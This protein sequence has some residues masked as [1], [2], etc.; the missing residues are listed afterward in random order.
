MPKRAGKGTFSG[1]RFPLATAYVDPP[2]RNRWLLAGIVLAAVVATLL[3][4]DFFWGRSALLSSG[5]VAS[6]HAGLE[7]YCGNCHTRFSVGDSG[8]DPAK[9]A[10]CHEPAASTVGVHTFDA[11]YVYRSG[12]PGRAYRRDGETA[13]AACHPEHRGRAATIT[14]V[15]DARCVACHEFDSFNDGHPQFS[16]LAANGSDQGTLSFGH[17]RHVKEIRDR[18]R[19]DD[20]EQTC[21]RCHTPS[22][23]GRGF[24]PI[25]FERICIT[26]H[27]GAGVRSANLRTRAPGAPI[28]V[29]EQAGVRIDAGVETLESIR[30]RG[31]LG[32][33]W[34]ATMDPAE[35]RVSG[36]RVMK[37]PVQHRDPWITHNLRQI[38][39]AI[40]PSSEL[41]DLLAASAQVPDSEVHVLYEEAI[42][43]LR[44]QAAELRGRPE[45]W[46]QEELAALEHLLAGVER[47][48]AD[49]DIALDPSRFSLVGRRDPR[50]SD[51]Q[52]DELL[53]LA[54]R[55]SAP[56]QQ[57][58]RIT[59]ASVARVQ[60]EQRE[61]RRAEFDHAVHALQRRCLDCHA[62]IPVLDYLQAAEPPPASVDGAAIVN[63]P[64]VETCQGCHTPELVSNACT[65]CHLFHPAAYDSDRL[66]LFVQ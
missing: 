54:D 63:L 61:L 30:A 38:R 43:A 28:V 16:I 20:I 36:S 31:D 53:D 60:Q 1:A 17:T 59:D 12:D 23:G 13:C 57:C 26:C 8:A 11:H 55:L 51:A 62:R 66:R 47:G 25:A 6:A 22:A 64:G 18:E 33:Q 39:A 50:L 48:V 19:L 46:V 9:C 42:A 58:H 3:F 27:L 41:A 56:C 40:Y 21:L 45:G 10:A 15:N 14:S 44:G 2:S 35:F 52:V 49:H 5:P 29:Q 37:N 34:A 65:T 32:T 24:E 7:G 4:G